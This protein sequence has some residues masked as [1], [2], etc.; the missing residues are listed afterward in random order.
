MNNKKN[1]QKLSSSFLTTTPEK[2]KK[3]ALKLLNK[4]ADSFNSIKEENI[5]LK[6]QIED[7]NLNLK[8]N[9][10]IIDNFFSDKNTSEKEISLINNLKQENKYLYE[11]KEILEKKNLELINKINANEQTYIESMTQTK[12]ENESLK[13]KIFLLEQSCQK[14]DN[15]IDQQKSKLNINKKRAGYYN[16]NEI[17]ITNPSKVVNNINNELLV[18]KDMYKELTHIIKDN[19]ANLEKYEKKILELQ[20]EN[21]T[22]RQ[23]YK[24]H[25]FNSNKERETLMNTIQRERSFMNKKN[26]SEDNKKNKNKKGSKNEKKFDNENLSAVTE[27][28]DNLIENQN[29]QNKR[30]N[31]KKLLGIE[32]NKK[33]E[34]SDIFTD[35][36]FI[37]KINRKQFEH[38][39]FIDILKNVGLTLEKFEN[40]SK[41]KSFAKFTEI[42][43]MLLNLI[44]DKE[45]QIRILRK[46]NEFLN[47]NNFKINEEN[48]LLTNQ[49][50][51]KDTMLKNNNND[52]LNPKLQKTMHLYKEYLNNNQKEDSSP[53]DIIYDIKPHILEKQQKNYYYLNG[54]NS[55][56]KDEI[57]DTVVYNKD[58][59]EKINIKNNLE[60]NLNINEENIIK[61][62]KSSAVKIPSEII[63]N[64]FGNNKFTGTL[65]SV[66]SSEFRE[67]CPGPESFLST[68]K[69]DDMNGTQK[70]NGLK[71]IQKLYIKN[72]N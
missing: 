38:E 7:L 39:D 26:V 62:E 72:S 56:K 9:K 16:N 53:S 42:I 28:Y 12:E 67:G 44:K 49:I 36:Y 37:S 27:T 11:Q 52:D 33:Y 54:D 64:N 22:L 30:Q 3:T 5:F 1:K 70:T 50:K 8:I 14:K 65:V 66:T 17:F 31:Y 34:K 47:E 61:K 68:I 60:N 51:L 4:Y 46:E 24:T 48:I 13:T 57:N 71:E 15:I 58:T 20:N 41:M 19:R 23:D 29:N 45:R 55:L 40:M 10:S 59:N 2:G 18:Y 63:K 69:F 32:K 6:K 43:E 21:Q 25:I 35:N